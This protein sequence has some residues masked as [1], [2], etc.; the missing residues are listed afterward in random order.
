MWDAVTAV[1]EQHD[2][3]IYVGDG[4]ETVVVVNAGPETVELRAWP[5]AAPPP[6][7]APIACLKVRPGNSKAVRGALIRVSLFGRE[8]FGRSGNR[9]A[10][11]GWSIKS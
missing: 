6:D 5:Q 11:V 10:A 4:A 7:V 1:D 3:T 2:P 8:Q 9:F